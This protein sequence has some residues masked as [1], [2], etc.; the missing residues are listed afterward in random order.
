MNAAQIAGAAAIGAAAVGAWGAV[1]PQSQIFGRTIRE[2]GEAQTLALT[3]DDGPNPA[4]TPALLDLLE[5][6]DARA[7]FFLMG[8]R[9][10]AF[11]EI[12]RETAARGHAI[13]NHTETHANLI[14]LSREE[15]REE[16]NR[17][18]E[19]IRAAAGG[20][21][22]RWMRPPFGFRGPQLGGR[23]ARARIFGRGDVVEVGVGLEAAAGEPRDSSLAA[24]GRR[25]YRAPARWRLSRAGRRPAAHGGSAGALAAA[26]ERCGNSFCDARFGGRRGGG[27][28]GGDGGRENLKVRQARMG[29][30]WTTE[31]FTTRKTKRN[32][33]R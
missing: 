13:G 14:F 28:C 21:E 31:N 25:G 15:L 11:P 5:K 4:A 26:M 10:R 33:F 24:R 17:C 22:L 29:E 19:A 1:H 18:G 20:G 7:T 2:T 32:R 23:G 8:S 27:K 6:H 16:L 3:F 9:V 12:V 30:P